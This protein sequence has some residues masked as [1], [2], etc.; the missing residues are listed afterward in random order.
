MIPAIPFL[1]KI[2]L[3]S[4]GFVIPWRVWL[5]LGLATAVGLFIWRF[6][7]LSNTVKNYKAEVEIQQRKFNSN[8]DLV[9]ELSRSDDQIMYEQMRRA[10]EA[11][12]SAKSWLRL[13]DPEVLKTGKTPKGYAKQL[14]EVR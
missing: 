14:N 8:K 10:E 12:D 11:G 9:E 1:A 5:I 2:G 7:Y 13:Q 3:S 6:N 4:L